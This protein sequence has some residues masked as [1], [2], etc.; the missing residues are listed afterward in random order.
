AAASYAARR[1]RGL[2]WLPSDRGRKLGMAGGGAVAPV[3]ARA[4]KASYL[5]NCRC[6]PLDSEAGS[7]TKTALARRIHVEDFLPF[8]APRG[9]SRRMRDPSLRIVRVR[10]GAQAAA[11]RKRARQG[12]GVRRV[13]FG[14]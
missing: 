14:R 7:I 13:G 12:P 1:G 10:G 11:P 8:R 9:D 5:S 3:V 2:V 6:L 4:A